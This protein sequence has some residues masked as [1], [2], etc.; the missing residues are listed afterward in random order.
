MSLEDIRKRL[1]SL[2]VRTDH[3]LVGSEEAERLAKTT[4]KHFGIPEQLVSVVAFKSASRVTFDFCY[5]SVSLV[6]YQLLFGDEMQIGWVET[7]TIRMI[8]EI[9]IKM[10]LNLDP[11]KIRNMFNK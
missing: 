9:L 4:A 2:R 5:N 10:H 8:G 6:R 1:E 11:E 3:D 7:C